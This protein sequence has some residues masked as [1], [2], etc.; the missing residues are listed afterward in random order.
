MY[1]YRMAVTMVTTRYMS[2]AMLWL[3]RAPSKQSS[4]TCQKRVLYVRLLVH[5]VSICIVE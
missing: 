3:W 1:I 4:K 5:H 2:M